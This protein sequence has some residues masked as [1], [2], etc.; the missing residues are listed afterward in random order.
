MVT[1]EYIP[2]YSLAD[3]VRFEIDM[4]VYG[5]L[6]NLDLPRFDIQ[7]THPYYLVPTG[8]HQQFA[9]IVQC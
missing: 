3:M 2:S 7:T 1:L 8:L 5:V 4:A 9:D 6:Y